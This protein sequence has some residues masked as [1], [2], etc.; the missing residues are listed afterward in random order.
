MALV[1]RDLLIK[2]GRF[3]L[4]TCVHV[5]K[6]RRGLVKDRKAAF[7]LEII[8]TIS[9]ASTALLRSYSH[10]NLRTQQF[11]REDAVAGFCAAKWLTRSQEGECI[12]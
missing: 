12:Q 11:G 10:R 7:L 8:S 1:F 6:G 5:V 4:C 3:Y 2:R 9:L